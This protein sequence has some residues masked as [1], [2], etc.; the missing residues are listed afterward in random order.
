[1]S[2]HS[3]TAITAAAG[4]AVAALGVAVAATAV[5]AAAATTCSCHNYLCRRH[6][7]PSRQHP[8]AAPS[9]TSSTRLPTK[10]K[11]IA[12]VPMKHRSER[13]PGKN[14]RT[15]GA[16]PLAF[17]VMRTLLASPSITAVVVNTDSDALKQLLSSEFPTVIIVDRP[18]NLCG[19]DVPMNEILLH[20]TAMFSADVFLQTHATNPFLRT[21]TIEAALKEFLQRYPRD[22]DSLF[23]VR[24]WQTRLYD[25]NCVA[26]NHNS[27]ELLRT[28]DLAPIFEEVHTH[29]HAHTQHSC[30][31]A[32]NSHTLRLWQSSSCAPV[33]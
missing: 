17:W 27:E 26:L 9:A 33:R 19:D 18:P 23:S 16:E 4:S 30:Q 12:L 21:A 29:T 25:S 5:A 13:V 20:D 32:V 3:Q 8:V 28:Q 2:A 1:M 11:I 10:P 31:R 22:C 15:L 6:T 24:Q 14:Y 7:S